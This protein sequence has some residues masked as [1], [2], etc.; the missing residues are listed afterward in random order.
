M[1]SSWSGKTS[2]SA[3]TIT[4]GLRLLGDEGG[5][6]DGLFRQGG[7]AEAIQGGG[8]E[9]IA[10]AVEGARGGLEGDLGLE[11]TLVERCAIG[12]KIDPLRDAD[13]QAERQIDPF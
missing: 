13:G 2:Q 12:Q 6:G 10:F 3:Q 5:A 9:I 11:P 7:F 8:E 4:S 1:K